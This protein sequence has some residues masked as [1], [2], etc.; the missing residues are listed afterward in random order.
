[1]K[2]TLELK[3]AALDLIDDMAAWSV[4]DVLSC[5]EMSAGVDE[6]ALR[7]AAEYFVGE[8]RFAEIMDAIKEW[9]QGES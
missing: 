9:K 4:A 3:G 7:Y 6:K 5:P 1:M 8:D 2:V